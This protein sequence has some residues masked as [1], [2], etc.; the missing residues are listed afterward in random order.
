MRVCANSISWIW[1]LVLLSPLSISAHELTL[2]NHLPRGR[3]SLLVYKLPYI[4]ATDTGGNCVWD[5]SRLSL[6]SATTI[7]ADF[8]LPLLTDTTRIGLHREHS[9]YYFHITQDTLWQTGYETSLTHMHY[10]NPIALLHFPF[11]YGDTINSIFE[12]NGQYCHLIPL[13]VEGTN[14][15]CIDAIG[16]LILPED[17]FAN[18]VQVHVQ[19]QYFEKNKPLHKIFEERHLWYA[20]YCRYPL[21]ENV[22]TNYIKQTDTIT[23]AATYYNPQEPMAIPIRE[24][25]LLESERDEALSDSI[26]TNVS[27]LP[28]PVYTDLNIQYTLIRAAQVYISVHYN[29]GAMTFQTTPKQETEGEKIV[30]VN[31]SGMPTGAYVVYIH[32][33][34]TI[35][36]GNIIKL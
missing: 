31:M 20:P 21:L 16:K 26:V 34:D 19:M 30:Y 35:V 5:F 15:T 11:A 28:N 6:D 23:I 7:S 17:T 22:L 2:G 18:T 1:G 29:G 13:S 27:Y 8:F 32:A 3:D 4:A 25:L 33:D 12:G 24:Q 9:N 14:S 10:S 36:S